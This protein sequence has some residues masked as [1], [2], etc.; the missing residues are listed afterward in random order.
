MYSSAGSDH[1]RSKG[2]VPNLTHPDC[3]VLTSGNFFLKGLSREDWNALRGWKQQCMGHGAVC[4]RRPNSEY[5]SIPFSTER[6]V[7]E[8]CGI[9]LQSRTRRFLKILLNPVGR[10]LKIISDGVRGGNPNGIRVEIEKRVGRPIP[11]TLS[12]QVGGLESQ[13]FVLLLVWSPVPCTCSASDGGHKRASLVSESNKSGSDSSLTS[14]A[15]RL[16]SPS[17]NTQNQPGINPLQLVSPEESTMA[18]STEE[19][20]LNIDYL[21]KCDIT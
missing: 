19:A 17:K 16:P 1:S 18:A 5:G 20:R 6:Y 2:Q 7:L 10:L 11:T 8:L 13:V 9:P 3:H 14:P 21:P 12:A 15:V 4:W